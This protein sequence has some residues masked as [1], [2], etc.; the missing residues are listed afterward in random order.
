M[1]IEEALKQ[2]VTDGIKTSLREPWAM[3]IDDFFNDGEMKRVVK[4]AIKEAVKEAID[5]NMDWDALNKAIANGV[6]DAVTDSR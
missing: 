1:S 2:G 3:H 4:E 5:R 6:G